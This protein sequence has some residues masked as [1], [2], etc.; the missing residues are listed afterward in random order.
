MALSK[1]TILKIRLRAYYINFMCWISRGRLVM[2]SDENYVPRLRRR[3]N[4][5]WLFSEKL[6]KVY[7]PD[8]PL[9]FGIVGNN[10]KDDWGK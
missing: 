4:A 1:L 3:K 6:G 8:D 9:P 10:Q 5:G 2:V 7:G